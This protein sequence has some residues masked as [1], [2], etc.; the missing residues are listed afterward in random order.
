MPAH[1]Y[2]QSV[3][4]SIRDRKHTPRLQ[5]DARAADVPAYIRAKWGARLVIDLD[6]SWPLNLE[7][8]KAGVEV[9]LAFSGLVVRCVLPW[10]SIYVVIDRDTGNGA[11][12]EANA[13]HAPWSDATPP[14]P[15]APLEPPKLH[16]TAITGGERAKSSPAASALSDGIAQRRRAGLRV[17]KGAKDEA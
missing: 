16:L 10:S 9:D 6:G 8:T 7:Y 3:I 2:I 17:I 12:F 5:L 1:H 13:P 14:A 11:V 4:E 15:P